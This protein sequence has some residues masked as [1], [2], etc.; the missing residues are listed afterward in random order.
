MIAS[1]SYF[2]VRAQD[3]SSFQKRNYQLWLVDKTKEN[4]A[5]CNFLKIGAKKIQYIDS[6]Y[7]DALK[8]F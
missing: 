4:I 6:S 8:K 1:K 3:I 5:N 2:L 7:T